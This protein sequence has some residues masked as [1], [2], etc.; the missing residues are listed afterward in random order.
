[1]LKVILMIKKFLLAVTLAVTSVASFASSGL[2]VQ[3]DVLGSK[4]ELKDTGKLKKNKAGVRVAVGKDTGDIRYQADYAYFGKITEDEF[5]AQSHSVGFS[6]IYDFDTKTALTPYVGARLGVNALK[7]KD[8]NLETIET[9]DNTTTPPAV[10][11]EKVGHAFSKTKTQV[12]AG[13]LAGVQYNINN[14]FAVNA[15]V[16]YNY[17]GKVDGVKFNQYGANI[18]VRYNF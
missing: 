4:V 11:V 16:E 17:L 10:T 1:M 2:Y 13:V 7:I 14:Q 3:G 12:G 8:S 6:A 9:T 18:G 5:S 15:G